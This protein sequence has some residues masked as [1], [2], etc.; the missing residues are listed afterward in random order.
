MRVERDTEIESERDTKVQ[1]NGD[2]ILSDEMIT[3]E[4]IGDD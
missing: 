1:S 3:C 4:L 2:L